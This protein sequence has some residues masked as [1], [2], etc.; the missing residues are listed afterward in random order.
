MIREESKYNLFA[1]L[2]KIKVVNILE[3]DQILNI[4][5]NYDITNKNEYHWDGYAHQGMIKYTVFQ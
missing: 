4:P 1:S 5:K 3:V 2:E